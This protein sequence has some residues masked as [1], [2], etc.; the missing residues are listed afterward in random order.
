MKQQRIHANCLTG[1]LPSRLGMVDAALSRPLSN[2]QFE[3]AE[4][5]QSA[6]EEK[7]NHLIN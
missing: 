4:M 3:Y 6:T 5:V 2:Y 1:T 7:L